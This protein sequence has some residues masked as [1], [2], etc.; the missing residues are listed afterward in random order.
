MESLQILHKGLDNDIPTTEIIDQ[1]LAELNRRVDGAKLKAF[2]GT[3]DQI[4]N[5]IS[6]A[7][8]QFEAAKEML[9]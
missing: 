4:K 6:G 8:R 5:Q 2:M 1:Q 3:P 9:K 7:E